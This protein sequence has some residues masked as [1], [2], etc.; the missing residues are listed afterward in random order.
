MHNAD[1]YKLLAEADATA[2]EVTV[3]LPVL[4]ET[5]ELVTVPETALT[6]EVTRM[7]DEA[8]GTDVTTDAEGV[9]VMNESA[10]DDTLAVAVGQR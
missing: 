8:T 4:A 3:T 1:L 5:N 2:D 9:G 6:L 7:D 10:L